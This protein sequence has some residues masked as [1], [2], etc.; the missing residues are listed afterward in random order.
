MDTIVTV[1]S[2]YHIVLPLAVREALHVKPGQKMRI[3]TYDQ[4]IVLIPD[5]PIEEA[6]GWLV[7][8]NT[9][10]DREEADRV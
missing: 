2:K 5:R 4:R 8:L 1:S 3:L 9:E 7:G 10:V 6:Q